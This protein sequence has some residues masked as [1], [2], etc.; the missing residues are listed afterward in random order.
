VGLF[1]IPLAPV[2]N[3][4]I[5]I[6]TIMAERFLYLPAAGLIGCIAWATYRQPRFERAV[7]WTF[8]VICLAFIVR[9]HVRNED[10]T[11][12]HSLFAS[13]A[14]VV[15]NSYRA[16]LNL[17]VAKR[18]LGDMDGAIVDIDHAVAVLA[19]LPPELDDDG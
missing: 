15:P 17:G 11:T 13:A 7:T 19:A 14:R 18:D 6:N 5:L 12:M 10:W 16:R 9:T 2:S 1:F 4:A 8:A 3:I